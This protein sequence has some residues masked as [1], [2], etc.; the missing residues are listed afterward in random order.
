MHRNRLPVLL[1]LFAASVLLF[2]GIAGAAPEKVAA[3]P[4][5]I[6]DACQPSPNASTS[7]TATHLALPDQAPAWL[8]QA[9][10]GTGCSA[11]FCAG[12]AAN[13]EMC[14]NARICICI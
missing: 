13:G 2:G 7:G 3:A 11:A 5:P 10:I 9:P 6:L 14:V 1:A 12:C 8:P 4:A